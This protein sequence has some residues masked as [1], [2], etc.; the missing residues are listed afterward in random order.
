MIYAGVQKNVGPAG[1]VIVMG[2][3]LGTTL[4]GNDRNSGKG[5]NMAALPS[6]YWFP[7]GRFRYIGVIRA[8]SGKLQKMVKRI[9]SFFTQYRCRNSTFSCKAQLLRTQLLTEGTHGEFAENDG[10]CRCAGIR[11]GG[12]VRMTKIQ[13]FMRS[14]VT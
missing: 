14:V 11:K 10:V 3:C 1:M 2:I 9:P 7:V 12:K 5:R 4:P 8:G 6:L 13:L